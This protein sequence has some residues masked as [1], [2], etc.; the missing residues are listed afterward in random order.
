[1]LVRIDEELDELLKIYEVVEED[2][3]GPVNQNV[4]FKIANKIKE[5]WKEK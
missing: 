3:W 5:Q 4:A 1:M 2:D